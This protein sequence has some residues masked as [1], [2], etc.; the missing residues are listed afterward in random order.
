[1]ARAPEGD[2]DLQ[3]YSNI[4]AW[5]ERVEAL[6]GFVVFQKTPVGLAA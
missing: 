2:V 4:R 1:V 5:L 3:R 6:P